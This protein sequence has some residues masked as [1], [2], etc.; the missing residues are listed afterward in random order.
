[1][2]SLIVSTNEN[3]DVRRLGC[4]GW[5]GADELP[6]QESVAKSLVER[7][8]SSCGQ[9][10]PRRIPGTDSKF[11]RLSILVRPRSKQWDVVKRLAV[12]PKSPVEQFCVNDLDCDCRKCGNDDR[13]CPCLWVSQTKKFVLEGWFVRERSGRPLN[14]PEY[15]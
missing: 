1:M 13:L 8:Y 12:S 9:F 6:A 10:F 14:T 15:A 5:A 3:P 4:G 11:V 2:L 7:E